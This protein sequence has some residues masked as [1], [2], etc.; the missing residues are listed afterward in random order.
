[1]IIVASSHWSVS[2]FVLD[3]EDSEVPLGHTQPLSQDRFLTVVL[4][5]SQD[6]TSHG[7][8]ASS[9]VVATAWA[10]E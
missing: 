9:D 4:C 3:I 2:K 6:S 10:R 5:V 1:V 7:V 8:V